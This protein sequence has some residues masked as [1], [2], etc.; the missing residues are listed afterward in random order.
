MILS[1]QLCIHFHRP[2]YEYCTRKLPLVYFFN[3]CRNDQNISLRG[4]FLHTVL[5]LSMAFVY[6]P[7]L[8]SVSPSALYVSKV[9]FGPDSD[10]SSS[11]ILRDFLNSRPK[12]HAALST[13]MADCCPCQPSLSYL[14]R[15][16]NG[17]AAA[18]P[19]QAY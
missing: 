14:T 11:Y 6:A 1:Q 18:L 16:R 19:F 8:N 2:F 12:S 3:K 10:P 5:K 9:P 13:K 7:C 4:I 15:I 17:R